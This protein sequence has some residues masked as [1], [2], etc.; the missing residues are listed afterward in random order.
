MVS[1]VYTK[2]SS[3]I[4]ISIC[5]LSPKKSCGS[6]FKCDTSSGIV[7]V[8]YKHHDVVEAHSPESCK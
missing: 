2:H 1:N 7:S 5:L 4:I 8:Y 3:K 6:V